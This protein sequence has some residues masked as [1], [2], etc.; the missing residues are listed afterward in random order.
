MRAS[1]RPPGGLLAKALQQAKR[2]SRRALGRAGRKGRRV[3][4]VL[5]AYRGRAK[6]LVRRRTRQ[7]K[8]LVRRQRRYLRRRYLGPLARDLGVARKASALGRR[9]ALFGTPL[10]S[11]L[12]A[13]STWR[14]DTPRIALRNHFN[15][16]VWSTYRTHPPLRF[17][18]S[19][20]AE[21]DHWVNLLPEQV[22]P[23]G[24]VSS[25]QTARRRAA[26]PHVLEVEHWS[27]LAGLRGDSWSLVFRELKRVDAR[28]R[29]DECRAVV[30]LSR[31]LLEHFREFLAPDVW[32]KLDYAFPA[33]PSQPDL[34]TRSDDAFTIL[35]IGNRLSDKG[36]PEV[37]RA[38][39]VLRER[40]GGRVRMVLVSGT[41]PRGWHLPEGVALCNTLRMSPALKTSIYGSADVL[42]VPAFWETLGNFVEASAFGLPIVATRMHHEEDFVRD[43]QSGYLIDSPLHAYDEGFGTRWESWGEF[44]AEVERKRE[45]G[46]LAGVVRDLV[47]RLELMVSGGVDLK[48]LRGGARRLHAERFSPEVR[49]ARLRAIYAR[50]LGAT[51]GSWGD[52]KGVTSGRWQFGTTDARSESRC[53]S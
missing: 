13:L 45:A 46:E 14:G 15:H 1:A 47:D 44:M 37:L 38:F 21:L 40:H 24:E 52:R 34:Q 6:R 3:R 51:T 23:Q 36:I 22:G 11:D 41:V 19:P 8:R 48:D 32:P 12:R 31:G 4:E 53:P 29:R 42:V 50:A 5:S 33:W 20:L 30:T 16:P 25:G 27:L 9:K 18:P 39:E 28:V 26:R 17:A 49:N 10:R 43:G 35:T 2:E 7:L